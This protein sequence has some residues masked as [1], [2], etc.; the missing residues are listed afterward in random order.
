MDDLENLAPP[1][2]TRD[3]MVVVDDS[4]HTE[5]KMDLQ[6]EELQADS[7]PKRLNF[8]ELL[9]HFSTY[10]GMM[11]DD[12]TYLLQLFKEHEPVIS[13]SFHYNLYLEYMYYFYLLT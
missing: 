2:P 13:N 10:T 9:Q 11:L 6:E 8:I 12:I 3:E 1:T 7:V 5:D 4:N